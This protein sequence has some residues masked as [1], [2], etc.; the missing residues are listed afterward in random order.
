[1]IKTERL[2][3]VK[4]D[5][6]YAGDLYELWSNFEVIKYTY[7]NQLKSIDE[8]VDK[9]KMFID[10]TDEDFTN[11]FIILLDNKAVGIVG[12]P[13]INKENAEFGF[14]Y[15]LVEKYW[16]H[17]YISEAAM[18]FKKYLIDKYPNAVI[19]AD[20]VCE[21]AASLAILKKLGLKMIGIE[22][23]GFKLNNYELDLVKFSNVQ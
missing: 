4:F 23:K 22:E 14:Y 21:N 18:A 2:E 20:A 17:G 7:M 9:I 19:N 15:Q 16:G 1:M 6:K 5:L 13:V 11:N 12:A 8:C 10:Y 3:L